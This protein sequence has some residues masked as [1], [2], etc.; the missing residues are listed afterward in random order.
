M[1]V[2]SA[3]ELR[4]RRAGI[5][6]GPWSK[7]LADALRALAPNDETR[8]SV[9]GTGHIALEDL[10]LGPSDRRKGARLS[11][12]LR[13]HY[14]DPDGVTDPTEIVLRDALDEA[15]TVPQLYELA[16]Q[17]GYL[18]T[19]SVR[20]SA[21]RIL[22]GLLWSEAA[23]RFVAG[24]DYLAVSMLAARVGVSGLGPAQPPQPEPKA[25]LRFAGFLAHLRTFYADERIETWTRFLDDYVVEENEQGKLWDYLRG[26]RE[27]AP[28]RAAELLTGC[29]LFTA[30]LANAFHVL[31]SDELGRFGMIHAYWLQKFLGYKFEANGYVKD[32]E[33]WGRSD[34]WARS[35]AR[36][37][38]L[39]AE[40]EIREIATLVRE[41]FQEQL[42]LLEQT[43]EAVRVLATS[44]RG[45]VSGSRVR[46]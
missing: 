35:I 44:S 22:T 26:R 15:L 5:A 30:S 11:T 1:T 25:A 31:D 7:G 2:L 28:Q 29:A 21:R 23:R 40:V 46:N 41:Q 32:V 14:E 36:S 12:V 6:R 39:V 43:F 20:R 19:Q 13:L 37:P 33:R 4:S 8:V 18:P 17:T 10:R 16:V 24:Y 45:T 34:S 9:A 42:R 3:D 38:R 27:K